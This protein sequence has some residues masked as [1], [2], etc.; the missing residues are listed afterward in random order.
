MPEATM[1]HILTR[2]VRVEMG[3]GYFETVAAGT[4]VS[5]VEG[6]DCIRLPSGHII[7]NHDGLLRPADR[8]GYEVQCMQCLKTKAPHGRSLPGVVAP[9][10]CTWECPGYYEDPQ[11]D[12]LFP[13]EKLSEFG[14]GPEYKAYIEAKNKAEGKES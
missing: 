13:E 11:P 7:S 2:D 8:N 5:M 14:Y 1:K 6:F 10:Y 3:I 9:S 12:Y 4:E